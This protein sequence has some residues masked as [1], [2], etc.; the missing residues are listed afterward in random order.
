MN[1]I[2]SKIGLVQKALL[3]AIVIACVLTGTLLT[4]WASQPDMRLLFGNLGLEESAKITEKISEKDIPYEIRGN[5][6]SIYAPADQIYTLRASL[7]RD[8]LMPRSGE[9]GYEIFDNKQLGVSPMVQKMNYNRAIQGELARTIQVFDGVEFARV[10]IVRPEQT[11]FVS[12]GESATASVM[13]RLKP[14]Y[15]L[16]GGTVT[17]ISNL[18]AGAIEGLQSEHVTVTDSNGR[19]LSSQSSENGLVSGANNYKD[20]KSSVEHEMSGNILQSLEAVLGSGRATVIAQATLDM[21]QETIV[22]TTYEKGIPEEEIIEESSTIQQ[23]TLDENGNATQ[24]G[25]EEKSGTT[26]TTNKIPETITTTATVPGKVS[27]WS[28]AVIVDLAKE[29]VVAADDVESGDE[30]T[31]AAETGEPELI[32]TV[33]DVKEIIRVAVGP[34]LITDDNLSVKHVAFNRPPAA[35][36]TD[37]PTALDKLAPFAEIARQSSMG[38]FAICGLLVLKIFTRAGKQAAVSNSQTSDSNQTQALSL[39]SSPMLTG[40]GNEAITAIRNQINWQLREN[41]E[42]TRQLFSSWLSEDS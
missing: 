8:G 41:P 16:N 12:E 15:Q 30:S 36:F 17:A 21:T 13:L 24:A 33:E 35:L 3:A 31:A 42:Q 5:G 22:K 20:Y 40:G 14:G 27:A 4:K 26:T 19:M 6:S 39:S 18:V 34:D 25:N 11:M 32:M 9:P 7:A 23:P 28:V 29:K 10:H 1:I 38:I 2:W 37:E